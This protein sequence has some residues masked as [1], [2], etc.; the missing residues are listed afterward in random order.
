MLEC[1][2]RMYSLRCKDKPQASPRLVLRTVKFRCVLAGRAFP[3]SVSITGH[4]FCMW[5]FLILHNNVVTL[6]NDPWDLC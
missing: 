6:P 5:T 2:A 1:T 4:A 3:G